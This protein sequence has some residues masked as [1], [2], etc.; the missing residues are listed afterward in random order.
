M[1]A[2]T[3][4]LLLLSAILLSAAERHVLRFRLTSGFI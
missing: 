3:L 4:F 2:L 1:R